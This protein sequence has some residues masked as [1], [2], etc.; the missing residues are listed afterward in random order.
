MGL[1]GHRMASMPQLVIWECTKSGTINSVPKYIW[2]G[3]IYMRPTLC[4]DHNLFLSLTCFIFYEDKIKR[5]RFA[6]CTLHVDVWNNDIHSGRPESI[7]RLT[8]SSSIELTF[9]SFQ[10]TSQIILE[11]YTIMLEHKITIL[12]QMGSLGQQKGPCIWLHW[13]FIVEASC[14]AGPPGLKIHTFSFYTKLPGAVIHLQ[15][16]LGRSIFKP[17]PAYC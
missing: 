2:E 12:M 17:K 10:S 7:T 5:W 16:L 14:D 1:A 6:T 15:H 9:Q 8:F 11:T 3:Q 13:E 4:G